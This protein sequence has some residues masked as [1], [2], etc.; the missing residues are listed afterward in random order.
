MIDLTKIKEAEAALAAAKREA[1]EYPPFELH[2][3]GKSKTILHAHV[4]IDT[5]EVRVVMRE[6]FD[7]ETAKEAARIEKD[8][9]RSCGIG[10]G[11][12]STLSIHPHQLHPFYEWLKGIVSMTAYVPPPWP[13]EPIVKTVEKEVVKTVTEKD[14]SAFVATLGLLCVSVLVNIILAGR[15]SS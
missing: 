4:Y 7:S 12:Q 6:D 10:S 11:P 5:T 8:W 2:C 3:G 15:L 14:Y 13:K 1:M 9:R